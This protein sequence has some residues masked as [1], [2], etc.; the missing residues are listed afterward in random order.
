TT[1]RI[2]LFSNDTCDPSGY[3]EG[4]GLFTPV[5][6]GQVG[7]N[8]GIVM[9]TTDAAGNA[10]FGPTTFSDSYVSSVVTATATD[11]AGNTS[12][13]SAC[14]LPPTSIAMTSSRNPLE[15]G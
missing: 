4:S 2:E 10:S 9:V 7:G 8:F 3:G 1:F 6:G 14:L 15:P 11:A 12:E 5:L 13:F